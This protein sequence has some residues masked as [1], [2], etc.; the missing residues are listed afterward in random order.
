MAL[1]KAQL[2][3]D[4]LPVKL[5]DTVKISRTCSKSKPLNPPTVLHFLVLVHNPKT[6]PF[7][8]HVY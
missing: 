1:Y 5:H 7:L 2:L 4:F 8:L 6:H 3:Y